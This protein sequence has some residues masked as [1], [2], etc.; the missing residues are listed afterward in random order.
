MSL[1]RSVSNSMAKRQL[2]QLTEWAQRQARV[3]DALVQ[4]LITKGTLTAE[5]LMA[6][7]ES[8]AGEPLDSDKNDEQ[9]KS[10]D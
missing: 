8:P 3:V 1:E 6:A 9:E 4:V 7:V 2:I 10:L 5:E